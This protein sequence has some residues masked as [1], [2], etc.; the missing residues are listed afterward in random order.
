MV[1]FVILRRYLKSLYIFLPLVSLP[2]KPVMANEFIKYNI[3]GS[4][5]V[6]QIGDDIKIAFGGRIIFDTYD[7][8]VDFNEV[9]N[10]LS[11]DNNY[12]GTKTTRAIWNLDIDL[13]KNW[14]IKTE[15]GFLDA[16][17]LWEDAFVE[18]SKPDYSIYIGNNYQASSMEGQT[19]SGVYNFSYRS[20][21]SS[22]FARGGRTFGI[23]ARKYS[24][25]WQI[26]LGVFGDTINQKPDRLFSGPRQF[27]LRT[28]FVPIKEKN[29]LLHLGG[30][31]RFR[32]RDDGNL[33]SYSSRPIQFG[34]GAPYLQT[35]NIAKN[36]VT[37]GL[38]AYYIN[39]PYSLQFEAQKLYANGMNENF[40]FDGY[41]IEGVYFLTGESREFNFVRGVP[42][43]VRPKKPFGKNGI[44]AIS[45]VARYDYID[46]E[47]GN[48]GNPYA[49][50]TSLRNRGGTEYGYSL[51]INWYIFGRII[52][53]ATYGE[54]NFKNT[55]GLIDYN[56]QFISNPIGN[57]KAKLWALRTEIGF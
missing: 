29:K 34:I 51:G 17:P 15:H 25:D 13:G 2:L 48:L 14:K 55:R 30:N 18:Y 57:G 31:F 45:L 40:D 26:S 42:K 44:G 39:G 50:N 5:P 12:Q 49:I 33:I 36:D 1:V 20:L 35:G 46:F 9:Q 56:N 22:A 38:E 24:N 7:L 32:N 10:Q 21:M 4:T 28:S 43:P 11:R 47:D 41:Y 8:N 16:K 3:R 37:F 52:F 6:L 23:A 19:S 53:R 54:T 27:Q